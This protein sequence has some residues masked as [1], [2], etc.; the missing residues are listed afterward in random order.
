M[1]AEAQANAKQAENEEHR[2]QAGL[3]IIV[4]RCPGCK[5]TLAVNG[6]GRLICSCGQM[7]QFGSGSK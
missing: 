1:S 5:R 3:P 4:G 6:P 7:I 2:E